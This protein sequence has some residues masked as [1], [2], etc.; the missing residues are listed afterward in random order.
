MFVLPTL[1]L[2]YIQIMAQFL[3]VSPFLLALLVIASC[4]K[5]EE[6]PIR[7]TSPVERPQMLF[8]DTTF[9]DFYDG[10]LLSWRL[11]T[12][13]LERWG[14]AG[15]VF[16]KPIFVD[17][18]D[19]TGSKAAFLRSDSGEL[20][21][22]MTYVRAY[23]HVYALTPKGASVRADSLIWNKRDNK[24]HTASVV[25]VVSENGDVLQGRGFLSD[26]K[27]ENWQILSEVTGIFQDAASR[28]KDEDSVGRKELLPA[29]TAKKTSVPNPKAQPSPRT[30]PPSPRK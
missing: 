12:A 7:T 22:R 14:G 20:D 9:L 24:V 10:K 8:L 17:I 4:S 15:K 28:M 19:S 2:S 29:D 3:P 6:E 30:S 27:L 13:W 21:S 18:Y 1:L 25:R 16:A 23:G 5:I 26:A 11:K